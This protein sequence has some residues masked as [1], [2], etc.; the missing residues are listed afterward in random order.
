M[1][2]SLLNEEQRSAVTTTEGPLLIL[3][4]AGSGKTR[5]LTHRIAYLIEDRQVAPWNILALTFTN[6]AA[7][8]M[9][10]RVNGLI[11]YSADK[12][13]LATFHG[14]CARL[15][16]MEIDKLGYDKAFIIYDDYDQQVLIGHII[17]DLCL[18]EKTYSKRMLSAIFSEA[19]NSSLNPSE[20]LDQSG[21]PMP[22]RQAFRLYQ[23]RLRASNSLD[24][25]DL[26][27]KVIELFEKFPEVLDS[28]R[29][30]YKYILVDEYQD[31]NLAQYHIVSLLA[32]NHRNICVVGDD[33]QSIYGWRGADIRNI[34][35]FEKDFP[36]AIVIR[37]EQNYRSTDKILEAANCV[38]SNNYGRK[39]KTLWTDR[40]NGEDIE[41]YCADDEREEAAFICGKIAREVRYGGK[42]NDFA[43][44][45]RT[46][47]QSRII[48]M[49]LQS[50]S[51]PYKVYGGVSFFQRAEVKDI[52]CYLRLFENPSDNE[53]FLRIVNVPKRKIGAASLLELTKSAQAKGIPLLSAALDSV[54]LPKS[55]AEKLKAFT[56]PIM[57]L[58]SK[59][60]SIPLLTFT[61]ELLDK[62]QYDAYLLEDKKDTYETRREAVMELLGYIKEFEASYTDEGDILQ[63]FINNIA[64]FSNADQVDEHNGCVNLMTLHSAKGLEFP[65]VFLCGLEDRLFPS[66]KSL[67]EP[68]KLEEERRLCYVGIT[69]AMDKLY[70]TYARQRT[71][72]G[73]TEATV[74]SRFLKEL[75]TVVNIPSLVPTP[76]KFSD[77]KQSAFIPTATPVSKSAPPT[78]IELAI[79]ERVTH[80]VFG[81][82]I[83]KNLIGSGSTQ[84]VEI[85]FD[86]G[87]SK[88]FASAYAPLTK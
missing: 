35:E 79:G 17:K 58:Y 21:Q 80:R 24:F 50:Y 84:L 63:A 72:Y 26:L 71:M 78:P 37:L 36:G 68:N 62:I 52:L 7:R 42:Y 20:Y 69:R 40:K 51:I 43:I 4:G 13:L 44:L 60:G 65:T 41:V 87:V 34:L 88:K 16:S 47:A 2:L 29:E 67:Y 56:T 28:Y 77:R 74:P 33:D 53:A 85:L 30:R 54:D 55:V 61:E 23:E 82:G 32:K 1:D 59:Y 76:N 45:Y 25:D 5:V 83:I 11:S 19:K 46:H 18:D 9:R 14:F 10:E 70:I 86:N 6:K 48:E 57:E 39:S 75:E 22:V 3:A 81:S 73:Q 64:L 31:T 12:V 66:S 49:L 8:E 15:L 38:I 27:L